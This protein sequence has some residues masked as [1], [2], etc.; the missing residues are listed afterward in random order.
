MPGAYNAAMHCRP[1]HTVVVVTA[2]LLAGVAR[3]CAQ[4]TDPA[5]SVTCPPLSTLDNRQKPSG[6]EILIVKVGFSGVLNMPA[7]DQAQIAGSI[8][9]QAHGHSAIW[10]AGPWIF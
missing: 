2:C 4:S 10:V 9:Q 3:V 5:I 1:V 8:K 6:T 7:S